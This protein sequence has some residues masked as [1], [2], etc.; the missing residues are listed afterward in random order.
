M[1]IAFKQSTKTVR[2]GSS[3]LKD[4]ITRE[5]SIAHPSAIR[6]SSDRIF[7]FQSIDPQEWERC[8]HNPVAILESAT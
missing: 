4:H 2:R 5:N 3:G 7:L 6:H 1:V 8:G